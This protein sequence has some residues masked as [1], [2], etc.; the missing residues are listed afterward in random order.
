MFVSFDL[1]FAWR[2]NLQRNP[3]LDLSKDLAHYARLAHLVAPACFVGARML[4]GTGWLSM[5]PAQLPIVLFGSGHCIDFTSSLQF[6]FKN[7]HKGSPKLR[8]HSLPKQ[9]TPTQQLRAASI[10]FSVALINA[11]LLQALGLDDTRPISSL[12]AC[13]LP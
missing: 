13:R 1:S 6:L 12:H 2:A 5:L 10:S 4:A 11:R 7:A 8:H 9:R 3:L